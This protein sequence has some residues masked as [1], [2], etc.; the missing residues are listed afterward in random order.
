MAKHYEILT[1]EQTSFSEEGKFINTDVV[2]QKIT[3]QKAH[4]FELKLA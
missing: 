3:H 4:M 2:D 1:K